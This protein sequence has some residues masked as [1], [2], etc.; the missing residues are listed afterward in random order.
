MLWMSYVWPR[1]IGTDKSDEGGKPVKAPHFSEELSLG[2]SS[3]IMSTMVGT[4]EYL[5]EM[6]HLT[7]GHPSLERLSV[8]LGNSNPFGF[9]H[10]PVGQMG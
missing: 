9:H 5:S 3:M 10:V 7:E 6:S 8:Q 4:S 1:C 2:A